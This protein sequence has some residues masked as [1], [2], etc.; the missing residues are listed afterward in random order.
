LEL[1]L[2]LETHSVSVRIAR[3]HSS[4]FALLLIA[5]VD[6]QN[7]RGFLSTPRGPTFRDRIHYFGVQSF[8][9]FFWLVHAA[10]SIPIS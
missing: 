10:L 7:F 4:S 1:I 5:H 8:E 3:L 6:D 2:A 9:E